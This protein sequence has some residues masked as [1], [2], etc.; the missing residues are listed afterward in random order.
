MLEM[1]LYLCHCLASV[2]T[3]CLVRVIGPEDR[4]KQ[5]SILYDKEQEEKKKK[6]RKHR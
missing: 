2:E 4:G 1:Q 5:P 6:Q 3:Y